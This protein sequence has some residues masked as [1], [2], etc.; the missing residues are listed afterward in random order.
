MLFCFV[1]LVFDYLQTFDQLEREAHHG[2]LPPPVLEVEGLVVVDEDLG[3]QPLVVVKAF[4]PIRDGR[5][6]HFAWLLA[7]AH[8][9]LVASYILPKM[10]PYDSYEVCIRVASKETVR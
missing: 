5:V 9:L 7:Q 4:G 3:E 1:F 2:A 6:S 8:L 10:G